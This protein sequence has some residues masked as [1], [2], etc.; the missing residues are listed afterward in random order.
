M[1]AVVGGGERDLQC[2]QGCEEEELPSGVVGFSSVP[3]GMRDKGV[4]SCTLGVLCTPGASENFC[5]VSLFAANLGLILC[6][7]CVC[8]AL[9]GVSCACPSRGD[10]SPPVLVPN[11]LL[12]FN[13][14]GGHGHGMTQ[15]ALQHPCSCPLF[16]S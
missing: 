5:F 4:P 8:L 11:P 13:S 14:Q 6:C 7:L 16:L 2:P 10:L 3:G 15:T 1:V 9:S 12:A